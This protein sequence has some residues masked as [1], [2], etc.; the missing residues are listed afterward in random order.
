MGPHR[1]QGSLKARER[2][3][4]VREEDGAMEMEAEFRVIEQLALKMEVTPEQECGE[5]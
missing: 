1:L 4:E 3:R 2:S 5:P